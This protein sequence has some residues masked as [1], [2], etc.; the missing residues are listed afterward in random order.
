VRARAAATEA[1][2]V[3][4]EQ[5]ERDKTPW[6]EAVRLEQQ[7]APSLVPELVEKP[8]PRRSA[9]DHDNSG[10]AMGHLVHHLL[11]GSEKVDNRFDRNHL[12]RDAGK[13]LP[14][15]AASRIK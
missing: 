4:A 5:G 13:G 8:Q 10:T 7:D 12:F 6:A 11:S 3:T 1:T 9:A 15:D 2:D 14:V